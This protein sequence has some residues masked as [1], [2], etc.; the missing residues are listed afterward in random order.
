MNARVELPATREVRPTN[1]RRLPLHRTLTTPW[2][3]GKRSL[4]ATR[5]RC[6]KPSDGCP[7]MRSA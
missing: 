7:V 1:V 3:T 6:I 5:L 2:W 4:K